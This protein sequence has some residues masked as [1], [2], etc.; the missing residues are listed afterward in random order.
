[1]QPN[2][3]KQASVPALANEEPPWRRTRD[4]QL[5]VRIPPLIEQ[6]QQAFTRDLAQLVQ[7]QPGQW[8]AYAGELRIGFAKSQTELYQECL[9]RGFQPDE[10]LIRSIEP[11]V[12]VIS[13]GFIQ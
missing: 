11:D 7:E 10:F 8:V 2:P 9:R 3:E 5:P 4:D 12:G 6:A 1:M 13:L